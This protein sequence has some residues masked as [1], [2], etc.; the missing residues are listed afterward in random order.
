MENI[1]QLMNR[2]PVLLVKIENALCE[3]WRFHYVHLKSWIIRCVLCCAFNSADWCLSD[4]GCWGLVHALQGVFAPAGI[5]ARGKIHQGPGCLWQLAVLLGAS[6]AQRE[7]IVVIFN[8]QLL[9]SSIL[10]GY[11]IPLVNF[12]MNF[13][14]HYICVTFILT[15]TEVWAWGLCSDH[16][17]VWRWS[18]PLWTS[19]ST[20]STDCLWTYGCFSEN[21]R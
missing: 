5:A 6:H 7:G 17:C 16:S 1:T 21:Q 12:E 2:I 4:C 14:F 10:P 13:S 3:K 8:S 9:I 18:P 15:E 19:Q 11:M 20:W